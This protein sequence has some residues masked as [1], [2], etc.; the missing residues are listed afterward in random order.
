MIFI[1]IRSTSLKAAGEHTRITLKVIE[2]LT[3]ICNDSKRLLELDKNLQVLLEEFKKHLPHDQ[4]LIVRS[5]VVSRA[6]K[7]K[8]KY[9][10]IKRSLQC[11]QLNLAKKKG[12]KK[13]SSKFRNRVGSKADRLRKVELC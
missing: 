6:L 8:R 5:S 2:S 13:A 1:Q 9:A 4:Q 12:R 3:Y 11:S 10:Q 7:T